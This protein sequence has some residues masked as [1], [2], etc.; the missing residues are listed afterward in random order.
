MA[1]AVAVVGSL[2]SFF[3]LDASAYRRSSLTDTTT[4]VD[5]ALP[6]PLV[7]TPPAAVPQTNVIQAA[8]HDWINETVGAGDSMAKIFAR[9]GLTPAQLHTLMQQPEAHDYLRQL[10]PGQQLKLLVNQ[11]Q[12]VQ[13][14]VLAINRFDSFALQRN[15]SDYIASSHH[16][17]VET[18]I[19]H[20]V[21]TIDSS[22]YETGQRAGMSDALIMELA[23]TFGWDI[24]FALDLRNGD[25][26]A[27]V[28]E[29]H[30]LDGEKIDQGPIL[31][32]EFVSQGQVYRAVRYTDAD[33]NSNYYT[34][35]GISMRKAFLRT[36]V[37]FRRI[38]SR[39]GNR[40][41]PILNKMRLHKGVDYS[42]PV[43][44]PIRAA[45]DGK[46]IFKGTKGGYGRTIIIQH[47]GTYS[48]LYAHM[49]AYK[50]GINSGSHVRQ[51][52]VIGY[53]GSSGLATGPH[54]HYE[55]RVNGVHRNP[56]TVK[57][58]NAEPIPEKYLAA[59]LQQ[60]QPILASLD[61]IK[62]QT[63]VALHNPQ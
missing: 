33:G 6:P 9:L 5:S 29:E 32:A 11:D 20:A 54:L 16:R 10:H 55:F 3:S 14:L 50:K 35:E 62:Q 44:T 24:D 57:L 15:G 7:Q 58:P 27:V 31:A 1:A 19:N 22:L 61:A 53:V 48:T 30:F 59:F 39:F 49:S 8:E 43:G 28:F 2:L 63:S 47:G 45:G 4:P 51:G 41:H 56:L 37:D 40:H 46:I 42:A 52:Q 26:F 12:S 60:T 38:S 36:P 18:R 13:A 17:N 21:A 34:P 23:N 25:H